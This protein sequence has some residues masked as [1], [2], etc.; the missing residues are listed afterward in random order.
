MR[1]IFV[2]SAQ[3]SDAEKFTEWSKN[4]PNNLFDQDVARYPTTTTRCAFDN[5]GPIV[6]VP[7]QRP[8]MLDALAINPKADPLSV[9]LALKELTQDAVS[10]AYD[11]GRGE[12]YFFC[13]DDSTIEFAKKHAYEEMK[14][15]V[16]RIK[17]NAL[18]KT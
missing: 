9:A 6:F 11:E 4:T 18:E 10:S 16:F 12:I 15:K 13:H 2:R 1:H 7:V 5:A 17:T 8:L 14:V 3:P